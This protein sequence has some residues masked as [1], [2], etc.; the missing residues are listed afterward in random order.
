M[1]VGQY[2]VSNLRV[3]PAYG[4]WARHVKGLTV[5]NCFFNYE[6]RDSRF[7]IVFDDVNGARLSSVKMVRA[8]DN[9]YVIKVINSPNVATEK[10]VYYHDAWGNAPAEISRAV[11]TDSRGS[12]G[13]PASDEH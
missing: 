5:E 3:Q 7:A 9:A 10:A 2:N 4:L 6:T 11:H 12:K 8:R 1:G 13:Y